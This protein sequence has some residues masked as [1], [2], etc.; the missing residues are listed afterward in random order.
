MPLTV[1]PEVL[2]HWSP[3][4]G[5]EGTVVDLVTVSIPVRLAPLIAGKAPVIELAAMPKDST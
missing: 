2:N 5:L 4:L 1:E 3:A